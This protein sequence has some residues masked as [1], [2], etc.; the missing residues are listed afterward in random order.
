M[1]WHEQW[2]N[3]RGD[4]VW[5]QFTYSCSRPDTALTEG[6]LRVSVYFITAA[7]VRRMSADLPKR[8]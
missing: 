7:S 3:R 8:K 5:Y 4:V 6:P 1:L 2:E